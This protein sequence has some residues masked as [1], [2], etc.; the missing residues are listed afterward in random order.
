MRCGEVGNGTSEALGKH[1]TSTSAIITSNA[2]LA[3][4]AVIPSR[5]VRKG[6]VG[7]QGGYRGGRT[8]GVDGSH[9]RLSTWLS[10]RLH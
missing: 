2:G 8:C 6:Q 5:A 4:V 9:R 1:M 3:P 10:G 7:V